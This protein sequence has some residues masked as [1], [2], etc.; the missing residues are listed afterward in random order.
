[1]VTLKNNL[2]LFFTLESH[3]DVTIR[4]ELKEKVSTVFVSDLQPY[5]THKNARPLEKEAFYKASDG[6]FG[7]KDVLKERVKEGK[8]DRVLLQNTFNLSKKRKAFNVGAGP[9][10]Q[11]RQ[12]LQPPHSPPR[13]VLHPKGLLRQQAKS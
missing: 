5:V 6:L 2:N 7:G 1:M 11:K 8:S 3:Q 13:R 4:E 10:Q 12:K 9:S